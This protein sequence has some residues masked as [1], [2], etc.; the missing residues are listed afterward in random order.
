MLSDLQQSLPQRV[1]KLQKAFEVKDSEESK[2]VEALVS[3]IRGIAQKEPKRIAQLTH[4]WLQE[5]R[6]TNE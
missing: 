3:A 6:Q 1:N 2:E 5:E 4:E